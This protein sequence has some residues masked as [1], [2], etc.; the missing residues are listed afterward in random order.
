QHRLEMNRAFGTFLHP[1]ALAAFLVLGIPYFLGELG[2][3]VPQW[4]AARHGTK[5]EKTPDRQ[6]PGPEKKPTWITAVLTGI[7]CS[8]IARLIYPYLL[9]IIARDDVWRD[10]IA[11]NWTFFVGLPT[12]V[13]LCVFLLPRRF[14]THLTR[15]SVQLVLLAS[16]FLL[17]LYVLATTFSRGGILALIGASAIGVTLFL[18]GSDRMRPRLPLLL[19]GTVC[20]LIVLSLGIMGVSGWAQEGPGEV[21]P[22]A[23]DRM[24]VPGVD[25][26]VQDLMSASSWKLRL[27]Y[28]RVGLIMAWD[29]IWSGVGPGNFGTV[30]ASYQYQ[31]AGGVQ[32]AHNVLVQTLA[33]TGLFGLIAFSAFWGYFFIWGA[34]RIVR[35]R[36]GAARCVLTG[37]YTGVLAFF[38]HSLVDFN[39]VNASLGSL[40][41]AMAALFYVRADLLASNTSTDAPHPHAISWKIALPLL[42]VVALLLGATIRVY[43]LDLALTGGNLKQKIVNVGNRRMVTDRIEVA[44]FLLRDIQQTPVNPQSPPFRWLSDI[45]LI[46]PNPDTAR[47]LGEIRVYVPE[48]PEHPRP[49]GAGETPP[50]QSLLIIRDTEQAEAIARDRSEEIVTRLAT[51]DRIYPHIPEVTVWMYQW[52][53]LLYETTS[54]P[55]EKSRYADASVEWTQR[56]VERSPYQAWYR[57]WHA[58]ALWIRAQRVQW[59][60]SLKDYELG[61]DEYAKACELYSSVPGGWNQYGD[62]LQKLGQA[63]V[64][65]GHDIEKGERLIRESEAA[66]AEARKRASAPQ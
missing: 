3:T 23:T 57:S 11:L 4:I 34:L 59:P 66:Y 18:A 35:E 48:H 37:L 13:G 12:I 21:A 53:Q 33:E 50:E 10:N 14:G 25:V 16:T 43:L 27:T 55:V 61:L 19:R 26:G 49:L 47:R 31:G 56:G 36:D 28:W 60:G 9:K 17:Q 39:F 2:R 40:V 32:A 41:F 15:L 64:N 22:M 54:D 46:I 7:L 20:I 29:N 45:A 5:K 24:N 42:T 1:N 65:T 6:S 38:L 52:Y 62:A 44:R 30:Y 63:L 58:R 51:I 8:G